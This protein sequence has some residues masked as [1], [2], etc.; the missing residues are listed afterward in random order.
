MFCGQ[1]LRNVD[2][3][4]FYPERFGPIRSGSVRFGQIRSGSV[5]FGPVWSCS[6]RFGQVRSDFG[7]KY[8]KFGPGLILW[9]LFNIGPVLI[10]NSLFPVRFGIR[11]NRPRR[12]LVKGYPKCSMTYE[13]I[14]TEKTCVLQ[15]SEHDRV[16]FIFKL[17]KTDVNSGW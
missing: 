17:Y 6:V 13:I 1:L 12:A 8:F 15:A 11:K 2:R 9:N 16:K 10:L 14:F 5:R 4:Q 3:T 7:F